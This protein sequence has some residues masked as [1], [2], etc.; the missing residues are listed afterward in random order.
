MPELPDGRMTETQDLLI[1]FFFK[2]FVFYGSKALPIRFDG[3]DPTT[4][5]NTY[6]EAVLSQFT[7]KPDDYELFLT[8]QLA[9]QKNCTGYKEANQPTQNTRTGRVLGVSSGPLPED[10]Q[11]IDQNEGAEPAEELE[12]ENQTQKRKLWKPPETADDK[13]NVCGSARTK[14]KVSYTEETDEEPQ[15][16]KA[17]SPHKKVKKQAD[18]VKTELKEMPKKKQKWVKQYPSHKIRPKS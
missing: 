9:E 5:S 13:E 7:V 17:A 12:T 4:N 3:D 6:G 1:K 14:T 8:K 10:L 16:P 18:Q 2:Q 11:Q 15:S